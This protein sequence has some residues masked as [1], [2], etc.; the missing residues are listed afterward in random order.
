MRPQSLVF[1]VQSTSPG[2]WPTV[3][4]VMSKPPSSFDSV[5]LDAPYHLAPTLSVEVTHRPALGVARRQLP[6]CL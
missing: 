2:A 5:Q 3:K 4:V 6:Q 1:V